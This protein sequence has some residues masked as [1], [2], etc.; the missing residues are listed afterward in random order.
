MTEIIANLFLLQLHLTSSSLTILLY[1]QCN[2]TPS[3]KMYRCVITLLSVLKVISQL[4][5]PSAV[6]G[7]KRCLNGERVPNTC[8]LNTFYIAL[9]TSGKCESSLSL[10]SE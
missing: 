10:F 7:C 2:Y 9:H 8:N 3:V 4:S 6:A 1:T 5:V